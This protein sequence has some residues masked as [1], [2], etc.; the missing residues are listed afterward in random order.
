MEKRNK[1][2]RLPNRRKNPSHKRNAK[3]E[4]IVK[5]SQ[6]STFINKFLDWTSG[7]N[8]ERYIG[9][10]LIP[11]PRSRLAH[12]KGDIATVYYGDDYLRAYHN[13]R[14]VK[15]YVHQPLISNEVDYYGVIYYKKRNAKE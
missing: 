1:P 6:L 2:N 10:I 12:W 5:K 7:R 11:S 13:G 8:K 9:R 15:M 3:G 4:S 14:K